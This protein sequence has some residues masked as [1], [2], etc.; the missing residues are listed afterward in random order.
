MVESSGINLVS[1][2]VSLSDSPAVGGNI[3]IYIPFGHFFISCMAELHH[4][5]TH[6][7]FRLFFYYSINLQLFMSPFE[8]LT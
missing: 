4:A 3:Y 1:E 8:L 6:R 2:R 7:A 5:E